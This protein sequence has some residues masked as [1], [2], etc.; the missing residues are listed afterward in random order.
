MK[1][2]DGNMNDPLAQLEASKPA[3]KDIFRDLLMEMKDFN[4]QITMKVLLSKQK[5]NS[6]KAITTVYFNSVA[7]T[8]TNLNNSGLDKSF[9]E[10]LHR[11]NNWINER[12]AWTIEYVDGEYLNIFVYNPLWESTYIEL[13]D[14]LKNTIKGLINIKNSHKKC[15]LWCH[16]RHLNPLSKNLQRITRV[17]QEY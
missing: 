16:I 3:M 15:F 13:P 4:D 11:I 6:D 2:K 12:S 8:V 7:K 14:K 17:D 1:D 10:L 9:Q 5:E